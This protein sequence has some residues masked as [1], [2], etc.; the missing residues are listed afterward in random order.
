MSLGGLEKCF[1]V[2]K[3]T[4]IRMKLTKSCETALEEVCRIVKTFENLQKFCFE[5]RLVRRW[6]LVTRISVVEAGMAGIFFLG[7]RSESGVCAA[8]RGAV[9]GVGAH[10]D[11]IQRDG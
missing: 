10:A 3:L 4:K 6:S 5:W 2:G 1:K 9:A 8:L 11:S 7:P